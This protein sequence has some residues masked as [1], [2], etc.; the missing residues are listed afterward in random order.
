[1][2]LAIEVS[3]LDFWTLVRKA[4]K[5]RFFI[6]TYRVMRGNGLGR[7]W[8]FVLALGVGAGKFSVMT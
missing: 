7:L 4:T 8:S 1:M 6:G 2:R 3:P 5:D